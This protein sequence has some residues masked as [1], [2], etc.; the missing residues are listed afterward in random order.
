MTT[1][2]DYPPGT[3]RGPYICGKGNSSSGGIQFLVR[4][5]DGGW[6]PVI[7]ERCEEAGA[8]KQAE[9]WSKKIKEEKA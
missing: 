2:I 8:R 5:N 9:E 1:F 6:I 7:R 4:T 3:I